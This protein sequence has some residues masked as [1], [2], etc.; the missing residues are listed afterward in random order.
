MLKYFRRIRRKLIDEGNL[1]W[2]LVYAIG[3]VLLVVI[4]ILIALQINN[5]NESRKE[6]DFEYKILKEMHNSLLKNIEI[7]NRSIFF[8]QEA[9]TSCKIILNQF[10]EN[11]TYQDS[12]DIHFAR[13]LF[14]FKVSAN[15]SA[16][17][18]AESHGLQIFKNDSIR[19]L[20]SFVYESS[21]EL[22]SALERRN[23]DY[24]YHN[25]MPVTRDLFESTNHGILQPP[26]WTYQGKMK[27]MNYEDLKN[28]PRYIHILK[29]LILNRETDITFLTR[30]IREMN[31]L[32]KMIRSEI[33]K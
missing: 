1:K 25:I 10:Q 32:E 5:W 9:K 31:E 3:E 30:L 4:G 28:Q 33:S 8:N 14:W 20:L 12:L 6:A 29:T 21:L 19:I 23:H 26:S 16:Y 17:K 11:P 18:T 22:I 2:Y 15:Y 7:V 27:P 13:S 24:F